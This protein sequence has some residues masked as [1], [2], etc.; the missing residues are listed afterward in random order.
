MGHRTHQFINLLEEIALLKKEP[1]GIDGF[2]QK[3]NNTWEKTTREMRCRN[4]DIHHYIPFLFLAKYEY[5]N[6]IRNYKLKLFKKS[7]IF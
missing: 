3:M 4:K 2:S 6:P 1:L 7:D 5:C